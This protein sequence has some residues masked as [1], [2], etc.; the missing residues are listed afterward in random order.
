LLPEILDAGEYAIKNADRIKIPTLLLCAG[1]DKIVSR[2]AIQEFNS[3]ASE[4]VTFVEY[5]NA[6]HC[7]H[8]DLVREEV[9]DQII[10]F[11]RSI[12]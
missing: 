1:A 7:L 3:K 5:P 12:G 9:L 11:I 2:D 8:L 10:G 6:Y 4:S